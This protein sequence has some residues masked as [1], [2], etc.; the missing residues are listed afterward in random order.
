[1]KTGHSCCAAKK[2]MIFSVKVLY[3]I[4]ESSRWGLALGNAANMLQYGRDFAVHFEIELVANGPA[5]GELRPDAARRAGIAGQLAA[6]APQVRICACCNALRANGISPEELYPF[7]T[8]VP[9][10][11][12]EIALRQEE[13]YSYIKP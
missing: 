1:M 3:H 2:G 4:D 9:A 5:V 13:G 7:V 12:V 10:G 6:L 8:P 11:V